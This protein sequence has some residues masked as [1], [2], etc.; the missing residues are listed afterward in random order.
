MDILIY[1]IFTLIGVMLGTLTGLTPGFHVNNIAIIAL[2]FYSQNI[3]EAV[4]LA[5]LIIAA[6][7]AHTFLDFIP[8]TFLGAPAEDTALSVLP[9]HR[10]LL[11]GRGYRAVYLSAIGSTLAV[12]F[13]ISIL[14]LL[15]IFFS[16]VQ[17][18]S[19]KYFIPPVLISIILYMLYLESK[20]SIKNMIYAANI[21]L[22]VSFLGIIVF[23]F[24]LNDNFVP[25]Q[26]GSSL[27]FPVFVG[28]FGM[29]NLI[30]SKD[31]IIPEQKIEKIEIT[32]KNNY[33]SFLGTLSGS[34]VGFLPGVTSGIGATI[35]R[36]F[37]KDE[38]TENFI[39][40]LGSVN[41]ANSIFNLAALFIILHPR[42]EAVN[43]IG[44]MISVE[45]WTNLVT[46]PSFLLLLLLSISI[47]SILSFFITIYTGKLFAVKMGKIGKNYGDISKIILI[48][49]FILIFLFTGPVGLLFSF[50]SLLIG[51]LPPKLGLMRVHLMS[52]IIIPVI[53]IYSGFL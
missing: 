47:S 3:A 53:L 8:S 23:S 43:V 38:D 15:Q 14:P 51:L 37:F 29:P 7:V 50:I 21:I 42:S 40:A 36:G 31:T 44:S 16:V 52:V 30:L 12:L 2:F 22:L 1:L 4:Y 13:A 28:L 17:Y 33:S 27:L 26:I 9:M 48:S 24:P 45:Q 6:M 11:D 41:T 18:D 46:I 10:M 25:F 34:L 49:L 32:G 5:G 35:S 19:I 20:K 39:I